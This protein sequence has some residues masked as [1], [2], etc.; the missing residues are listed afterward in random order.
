[1]DRHWRNRA[2]ARSSLAGI[3]QFYCWLWIPSARLC[4]DSAELAKAVADSSKVTGTNRGDFRNIVFLHHSV[5]HNL[6]QQGSV[7][8]LFTQ[9]GYQFWDHDY[10]YPGLT[11][12]TGNPLGFSYSVPAITPIPTV[13]QGFRST[14]ARSSAK[15]AQRSHA[16]RSRCLQ[17][18][19]SGQRH[20]E[21][22]TT[23]R[24]QGLVP[25]NARC[26]GSTSRQTI[27][28]THAATAE[29]GRDQTDIAGARDFANWLKSDEFLKG[30]P[31]IVTF[32]LFDRLAEDNARSADLNMLGRDYREGIDSHPTRSTDETI[33]PQF[34]AFVI[35]EIEQ[36]TESSAPVLTWRSERSRAAIASSA[37]RCTGLGLCRVSCAIWC[38]ARGVSGHPSSACRLQSLI[39]RLHRS[40]V[41]GVLT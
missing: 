4:S 7:R 32:D 39:R 9:A 2:G 5:G 26:D 21:Y 36:Y 23:R 12:P 20:Y 6:I 33:G 14:R 22:G 1:M 30:H 18:M 35:N 24:A 25:E 29:S 13:Y 41:T 10:N 34:V 8:E 38:L 15:H 27:R 28:R 37:G 40:S 31:N 17:V 3:C 11:D 19:F 16:A